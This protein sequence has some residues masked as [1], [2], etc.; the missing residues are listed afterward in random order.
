MSQY[1]YNTSCRPVNPFNMLYLCSTATCSAL[2]KVACSR[3]LFYSL[4]RL[5]AFCSVYRITSIFQLATQSHARRVRLVFSLLKVASVV[6]D[7]RDRCKSQKL[8][9][10]LTPLTKTLCGPFHFISFHFISFHFISFHFISFHFI[11]FHV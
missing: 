9:L 1:H 6:A 8:L 3:T 7:C 2:V 4:Q 11:S 5:S 10:H